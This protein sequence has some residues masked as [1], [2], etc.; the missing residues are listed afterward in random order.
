MDCRNIGRGLQEDW[1][2]LPEY[3]AGISL[4]ENLRRELQMN[5]R[6]KWMPKH[7]KLFR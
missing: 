5:I 1:R 3:W 7:W 4:T 2:V 6:E